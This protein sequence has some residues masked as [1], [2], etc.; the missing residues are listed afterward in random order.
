MD[1]PSRKKLLAL[2]T[3]L[4]SVAIGVI[5]LILITILDSRGPMIPP[6]PEAFGV[7]EVPFYD[8]YSMVQQLFL[9]LYL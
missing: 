6:P 9:Q 2:F 3:A 4:I 7:A 5:Y 8:F 1:L